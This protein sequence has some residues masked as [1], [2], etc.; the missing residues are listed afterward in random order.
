LKCHARKLRWIEEKEGKKEL[1]D[2]IPELRMLHVLLWKRRVTYTN[3]TIPKKLVVYLGMPP[4]MSLKGDRVPDACFLC[5]WHWII[6][7]NFFIY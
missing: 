1:A 3:L 2:V 4:D 5:M 6:F 7:F